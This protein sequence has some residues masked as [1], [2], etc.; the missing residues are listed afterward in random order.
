MTG[1]ILFHGLYP[2]PCFK[3]SRYLM[4]AALVVLQARDQKSMSRTY[5]K[6]SDAVVYACNPSAIN[7]HIPGA[8]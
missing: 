6:M 2:D 4:V 8:S 3:I 1:C 7:R 5:V